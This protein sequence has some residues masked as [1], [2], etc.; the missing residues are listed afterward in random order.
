MLAI[1]LEDSNLRNGE[2]AMLGQSIQPERFPHRHM[3]TLS[4]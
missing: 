3:R 2:G 1:L 4:T